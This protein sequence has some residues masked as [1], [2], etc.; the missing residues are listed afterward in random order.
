ML[1]L[2]TAL[3]RINPAVPTASAG[4]EHA[5]SGAPSGKAQRVKASLLALGVVY[6]D[7]GTSP[8][9]AL[10]ECFHGH[11]VRV[12]L[13]SVLGVLSL[14]LWSLAIIVSVKYLR[15]V[16]EADNHGEGGILALM[17]LALSRDRRP[18]Y[19]RVVIALGIAGAALLYGDG[20]ITPAISVLSA[21]EGLAL[22]APRAEPLVVPATCVILVALFLIQRR[23]TSTVGRI[24]VLH[25]SSQQEG[26]IYVPF[27]NWVLMLATLSL[28]IG[29]GSSS[30]LASA[31]GI[32]VTLSM[33]VT[34]LLAYTVTRSWGWGAP[35]ALAVTAGLL[36]IELLFLSANVEKIVHG[37][38][39]PLALG[40]VLSVVMFTWYRGRQL[41]GERLRRD[42]TPVSQLLQLL[43]RK[44]HVR[45]PGT[46]VFMTGLEQG[47][48]PAL[49]HNL[50]HN[51]VLHEV[52]VFLTIIT[53]DTARVAETERLRI[54]TIA[55]GIWRLVGRY[56]FMEQPDAPDLLLHSGLIYGMR[57][58]TFFLGQEHLLVSEQ[59][60]MRRWRLFLFTVLSRLAQPATRFFNIPPARVMEVGIQIVL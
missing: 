44:S 11:G 20:A 33:I 24:T 31:Y 9:Y 41:L 7:I 43:E 4:P 2:S 36:G 13:E 10:R 14:I 40:A 48:P 12:E 60:R 56:G 21:M 25:T 8:L 49:L 57:D 22:A 42:V 17:A 54:E 16:L 46:A 35:R 5:P 27:V 47:T 6:G 38:W 28:V 59:R 39:L 23:G 26:Q 50:D 53:L 51:H 34:T 1:K 3:S 18:R 15:Y 45:V 30:R 29:F 19:R 52:V 32:A 58:V 37:G 55:P